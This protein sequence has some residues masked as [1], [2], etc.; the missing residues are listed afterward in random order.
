[1]LKTKAL[2]MIKPNFMYLACQFLNLYP[3]ILS[4]SN[5]AQVLHYSEAPVSEINKYN[6]K[7][8]K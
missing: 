2:P 5:I 7:K 6:Y 1:M 3:S 4:H 8:K